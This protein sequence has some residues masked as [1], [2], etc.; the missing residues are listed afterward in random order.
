MPERTT[1]PRRIARAVIAA[2]MLI[3]LIAF[4][5]WVFSGILDTAR[6]LAP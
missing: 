3:A 4:W 6:R 2:L 5:A 1:P